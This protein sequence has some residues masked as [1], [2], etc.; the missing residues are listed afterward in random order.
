MG[1]AGVAITI[2]TGA[3]VSSV[4]L[5]ATT[6]YAGINSSEGGWIGGDATWAP[7]AAVAGAILGFA[8]GIVSAAVICGVGL[9]FWKSLLF[10]FTLNLL[11]AGAC[12]LLT[13]GRM[14]DGLRHPLYALPAVGFLTAAMISLV[15]ALTTTP[16]S[17]P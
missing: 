3:V 17:L 9:G 5:A 6:Y 15:R 12:F 4:A 1:I 16:A 11:V 7:L 8:L 13:G 14:S 10:G 2:G